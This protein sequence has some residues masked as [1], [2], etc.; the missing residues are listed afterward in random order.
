MREIMLHDI[1]GKVV[2]DAEGRKVGRIEE[3][4]ATI[5][6]HDHGNAYVVSELHV[7]AYG[8]LEAFAG[9]PFTRRLLQ[10]LGRFAPYREFRIP[11]DRIDMADPARPRLRVLRS[12]LP[13]SL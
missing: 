1:I 3:L 2:H 8:M 9:G 6:L 11:W 13:P 12:D 7:G 4:I 10:R 5:E